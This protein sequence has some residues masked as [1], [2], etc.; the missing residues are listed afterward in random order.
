MPKQ[1]TRKAVAKRCKLT[2]TGKIKRTTA[3]GS[4]LCTGKSRK[5]KRSLHQGRLVSKGDYKRIAV[6]LIG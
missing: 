5:H 3:G 4:H 1:K 6:C 2:A